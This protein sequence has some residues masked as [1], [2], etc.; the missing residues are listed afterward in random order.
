MYIYIIRHGESGTN[1]S[2]RLT[3]WYDTPL[4]DKGRND[5]KKTGLLLKDI[6]FDKVI[7]SDLAR[8]RETAAI[9]L[10]GYEY[11]FS[12]LVR[13]IN[14]GSLSYTKHSEIS[15]EI[16]QRTAKIG[17]AEFG[18]ESWDDV[19]L[20]ILQFMKYLE[21]LN[22]KNVA[23]FSHEGWLRAMMD[24]VLGVYVPRK[25]LCCMNGAIAVYKF[26]NDWQLHSL[27]N[28]IN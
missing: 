1:L 10:P 24:I 2:K 17:Y 6:K 4:T 22:C 18:G 19:R 9:A 8:A 3:G 26:D 7:V 15:Q 13:E 28:H 11:E 14:V 12:K 25:N 16:K 27:I 21:S 5:A 23:V 20:R